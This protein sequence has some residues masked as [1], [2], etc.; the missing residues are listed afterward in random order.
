LTRGA[1]TRDASSVSTQTEPQA[2]EAFAEAIRQFNEW[3]FYDCHETLEDIWRE[4]G[5]KTSESQ[6]ANFYQG[7]IKAAAGY[8][9]LLRDNYEGTLK[10]LGDTFRLLEPYRPRTLGVD[11]DALLGA[12]RET[13]E[14]VQSLGPG[15]LRRFDR[16]RIPTITLGAAA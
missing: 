12:V 4:L 6:L 9:H 11:V 14:Q 2:P 5:A 15:G 7:I 13:L 10:V 1:A 3:R 8:H 16:S